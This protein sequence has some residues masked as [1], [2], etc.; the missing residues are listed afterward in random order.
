MSLFEDI[1]ESIGNTISKLYWTYG[2]KYDNNTFWTKVIIYH[3]PKD[4]DGKVVVATLKEQGIDVQIEQEHCVS[5]L[6]G[7][8]IGYKNRGVW[9]QK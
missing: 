6:R 2:R 5:S 9:K 1:K 8:D 4:M 3:L 7:Y